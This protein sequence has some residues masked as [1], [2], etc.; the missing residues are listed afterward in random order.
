MANEDPN[1]FF[2]SSGP[3]LVDNNKW[4]RAFSINVPT[5]TIHLCI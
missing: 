4:V 5:L 2:T 3:Y 1:E